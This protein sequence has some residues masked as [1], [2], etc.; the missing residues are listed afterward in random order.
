MERSL[1][2]PALIASIAPANFDDAKRLVS[3]V[4]EG[5]NAIEYRLDF[6]AG[7]VSSRALLELDPRCAIVTYRTE[8]EG[9]KFRGTLEEYRRTVQ[10]AYEAGAAVDVELESGTLEDRA[11]LPDRRRVIGSRHADGEGGW[12]DAD[13]SRYL[14]ADVGAVKLVRTNVSSISGGTACLAALK[15]HSGSRPL[16]SF[17]T[18]TRGTFTRIVGA[19]F[20]SALTYGSVGAPTADGQVS[21]A[22][23]RDVYGVGRPAPPSGTFGIYGADVSR[24]LSP[25]IHNALFARRGLPFLYLPLSASDGAPSGGVLRRDLEALASADLLP[26]GLSVTSPFKSAFES[27]VEAIDEDDAV[28]RTG[29]ANTLVRVDAPEDGRRYLARNTDAEAVLEVLS[30]LRLAGRT[31]VVLGNGGAA[32]AAAYAAGLAGCT[33][34]LAG[35]D[36]RKVKPVADR[37]GA[38]AIAVGDLSSLEADVLVNATP[39][40]TKEDDPIPFPRSLLAR[41]PAVIDFVYRLSGETPLVREARER[42]CDTADGRELLARQAVGQARLFGAEGVSYEEIDGILRGP[43]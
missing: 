22:D 6:A 20:G 3:L 29:A 8:R 41:K 23:L 17:A 34:F 9:G 19:R 35:R 26:A 37:F 12:P 4:P 14:S 40:G 13:V 5:A 24:S 15:R 11:F 16:S 10:S 33:V 30:G 25:V 36:L 28:A 32:R 38:N 39:L 18:G 31:L 2:Y 27:I 1:P 21:V 43:R 7:R 42:G